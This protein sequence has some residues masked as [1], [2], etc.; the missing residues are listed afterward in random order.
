MPARGFL[1]FDE[2][3]ALGE[4]VREAAAELHVV[5]QR[6]TGWRAPMTGAAAREQLEHVR[7]KLRGAIVE[8]RRRA[9]ER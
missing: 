5:E 4:V 8:C 9:A 6:V 3:S 1:T 2:R 7:N